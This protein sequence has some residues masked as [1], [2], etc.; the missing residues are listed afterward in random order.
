M[1]K[2][3]SALPTSQSWKTSEKPALSFR[4]MIENAISN[5]TD[6]YRCLT[7]SQCHTT[8]GGGPKNE[9]LCLP[10]QAT[11]LTAA[12]LRHSVLD[13]TYGCISACFPHCIIIGKLSLPIP[14]SRPFPCSQSVSHCVDL[15]LIFPATCKEQ[16]PFYY[17]NELSQTLPPT[18][19][20]HHCNG[21]WA[22]K[23]ACLHLNSTLF[24]VSLGDLMNV[25]S[26]ITCSQLVHIL[27]KVVLCAVTMQMPGT[28]EYQ[29]SITAEHLLNGGCSWCS[30]WNCSNHFFPLTDL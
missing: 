12:A 27:Y 9:V 14:H 2:H 6:T 5:G 4:Y 15:T 18:S 10:G 17:W 3:Q 24:P 16:N 26:T 19:T 1:I 7:N 8:M 23:P 21:T 13:P 20:G 11:S 22:L 30:I 25:S 29:S 28:G